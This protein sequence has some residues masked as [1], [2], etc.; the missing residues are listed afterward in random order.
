MGF[1][2]FS[3][4]FFCFFFCCAEEIFFRVGAVSKLEGF[5]SGVEKLSNTI[6]Q[7][8]QSIS[9]VRHFMLSLKRHTEIMGQNL[10][11]NYSSGTVVCHFGVLFFFFFFCAIA[12]FSVVAAF[13]GVMAKE[14]VP[15]ICGKAHTNIFCLLAN[16][17]A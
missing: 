13:C 11:V 6:T 14:A 7:H 10:T 1:F 17:L 16:I 9:N 3:F 5:G 2:S 4:F 12:A 8:P 15:A